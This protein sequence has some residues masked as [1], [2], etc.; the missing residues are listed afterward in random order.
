MDLRL[1]VHIDIAGWQRLCDGSPYRSIRGD[2]S[3]EGAV[4]QYCKRRGLPWSPTFSSFAASIGQPSPYLFGYG[5]I[6]AHLVPERVL[7][8]DVVAAADDFRDDAVNRKGTAIQLV[9]ELPAR[10][11]QVERL[12]Q[13]AK[14]YAEIRILRELVRADVS[15]F[16]LSGSMA[17]TLMNSSQGTAR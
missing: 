6:V 1:T 4:R 3:F 9:G 2:E 13:T 17:A 8:G 11:G 14:K 5:D 16:D 12:A 15:Q 10:L 7:M